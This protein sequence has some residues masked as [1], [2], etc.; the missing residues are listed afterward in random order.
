MLRLQ[1]DPKLSLD[2]ASLLAR[3]R[4]LF[5]DTARVTRQI[6]APPVCRVDLNGTAQVITVNTNAIIT[7]LSAGTH[8]LD[9]HGWWSDT[10]YQYTPKESG[11]YAVYL[12]AEI[13]KDSGTV[14]AAA[15]TVI[16]IRKNAT[17]ET[18]AKWVSLP[19]VTSAML[20]VQTIVWLDGATD[21][22]DFIANYTASTGLSLYGGYNR[23]SA[24]V[25]FLGAD[26]LA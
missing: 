12:Q 11:Y 19:A 26:A 2:P 4:Q 15:T 21:Y 13:Y 8:A 16:A 23:T 18:Q 10:T 25:Q 3:V 1:L 6:Q 17:I 14:D 9:T 22:L 24:T 5:V 20:N 7:F